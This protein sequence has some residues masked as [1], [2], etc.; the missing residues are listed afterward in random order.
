MSKQKQSCAVRWLIIRNGAVGDTL[1]LSSLVQVIRNA[2]PHAWIEILGHR[3]RAG[4]LVD[5]HQ[6][7]AVTDGDD[8]GFYNLFAGE[9]ALGETLHDY[10]SGFTHIVYF[11]GKPSRHLEKRLQVNQSQWVKVMPVVPETNDVHIVEHYVSAVR[12]LYPVD[13][14]PLPNVVA[15]EELVL[16][17]EY[18]LYRIGARRDECLV[19]GAHVGA[20][21]EA[22]HAPM[23]LFHAVVEAFVKQC[24][25]HVLVPQGEADEARV[26]QFTHELDERVSYSVLVQ[27]TLKKLAAQLSLCDLVVGND[28]GVTHLA[29]ALGRPTLALFVGSDPVVW[30]PLGEARAAVAAIHSV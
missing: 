13:D 11:A 30:R 17:A 10:L 27:P 22:K 1:L 2:K 12:D 8:V 7:D 23:V 24:P 16:D 29:A 5:G 14:V 28:S 19:L 15:D 3:E 26:R 6:A 21:G 25:V 18:E 9:Q 4:L 20:G